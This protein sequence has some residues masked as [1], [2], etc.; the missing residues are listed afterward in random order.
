MCV[1]TRDGGC[2]SFKAG[3]AGTATAT[4]GSS[5]M[6]LPSLCP[7]LFP[8]GL[9]LIPGAG[10]DTWLRAAWQSLSGGPRGV[11]SMREGCCQHSAPHAAKHEPTAP[12]LPN[13]YCSCFETSAER[14]L[15]RIQHESLINSW[16]AF[17]KNVVYL[18]V[19]I[20]FCF[21]FLV[22]VVLLS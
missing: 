8:A 14:G 2:T 19:L 11:G 22:C 1:S 21:V 6:F 17:L 7:Q 4:A 12:S 5:G 20:F 10:C 13:T 16:R 15:P 3:R 9:W 18:F